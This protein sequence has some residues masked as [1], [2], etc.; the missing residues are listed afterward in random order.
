VTD[1]ADLKVGHQERQA[2]IDVL[3]T[4]ADEG[5]PMPQELAQRINTALA[6]RTF[7]DLDAL[8]ADL[9][10]APPSTELRRAGTFN[11]NQIGSDPDHRLQLSAGMS[12]HTQR[13]VWH[14]PPFLSLSAGMGSVKV[15]FLQAICSHELVDIAVSGGLGSI[16]LVVPIGWGANTDQVGKGMGNVSNRID[17]IADPGKPTLV[18]HGSSAVGSIVVRHPNWFDRRRLSRSLRA[19]SEGTAAGPI[20]PALPPPLSGPPSSRYPQDA[21]PQDAPP[22]H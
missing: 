18:L 20:G 4:A 9:P 5:R 15:D 14:V 21:T 13:G 8:V 3:R 1:P 11:V 16:T 2:T 12:S 7:A 6:A 10:V 22:D 17:A 19:M